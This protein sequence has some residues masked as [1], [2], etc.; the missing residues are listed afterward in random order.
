M[1]HF[2]LGWRT[3]LQPSLEEN[4]VLIL[5]IFLNKIGTE[6]SSKLGWR[7]KLRCDLATQMER[8]VAKPLSAPMGWLQLLYYPA[9]I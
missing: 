3:F 7:I 1:S 6:F 2:R 9:T 4:S 5:N 8:V